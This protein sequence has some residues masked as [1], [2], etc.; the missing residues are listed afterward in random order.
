M[1][2][3]YIGETI[4]SIK[5]E[6]LNDIMKKN[7]LWQKWRDEDKHKFHEEFDRI[8]K[9][10]KEDQGEYNRN[11]NQSQP[12]P[13]DS[14]YCILGYS[15]CIFLLYFYC[16]FIVFL[17]Y[18]YCVCQKCLFYRHGCDMFFKWGFFKQFTG[19]DDDWTNCVIGC[20]HHKYT[21]AAINF[22][23]RYN[24]IANETQLAYSSPK[25]HFVCQVLCSRHKKK[26][27]AVPLRG[28]NKGRIYHHFLDKYDPDSPTKKKNLQPIALLRY[29]TYLLYLFCM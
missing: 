9:L 16:I 19:D 11:K 17:L 24:Y 4:W 27:E 18:F 26:N 2:E 13:W 10:W 29:I 21:Q 6:V 1:D 28:S 23:V 8:D 20:K 7:N 3:K 14:K 12:S 15:V 22:L 5:N 25:D